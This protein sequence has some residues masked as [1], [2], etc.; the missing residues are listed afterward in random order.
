MTALASSAP[1]Q[2]PYFVSPNKEQAK[3]ASNEQRGG[4]FLK[5]DGFVA[6]PNCKG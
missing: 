1:T 4:G 6:T 2:V 3:S 5:P